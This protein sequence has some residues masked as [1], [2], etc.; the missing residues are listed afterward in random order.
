MNKMPQVAVKLRIALSIN[1]NNIK[2]SFIIRIDSG[3]TLT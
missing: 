3:K 1:E 2:Q